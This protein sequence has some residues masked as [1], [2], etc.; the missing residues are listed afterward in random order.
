MK[1]EN[2]KVLKLLETAMNRDIPMNQVIETVERHILLQAFRR[3]E[4]ISSVSQKLRIPRS[5]LFE[6]KKRYN[7]MITKNGSMPFSSIVAAKQNLAS[8]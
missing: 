7:L 4:S 1:N 5:T 2:D 8:N 6:K 3:H